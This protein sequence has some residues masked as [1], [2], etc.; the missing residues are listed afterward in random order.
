MPRTVS[1]SERNL[2]VG[3]RGEACFLSFYFIMFCIF[4]KITKLIT[5]ELTE[6]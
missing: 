4:V 3:K 6:E 2:F 5:I 1:Y